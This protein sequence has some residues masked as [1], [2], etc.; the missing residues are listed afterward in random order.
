[1]LQTQRLLHVTLSAVR[2]SSC[3]ELAK[4]A[5]AD[6]AAGVAADILCDLDITILR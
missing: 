5:A 3:F 6:D 1:M 4:D 2:Q